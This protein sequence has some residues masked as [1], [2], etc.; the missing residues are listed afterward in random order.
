MKAKVR[1]ASIDDCNKLGPKLREADKRELKAS[2]GYGPVTALTLSMN[3][4][5]NAYVLADKDD[6]AVLMF[7]VVSS[8]QDS[9][10]V[11]W[12]L[13]SNGIYKHTRKLTTE[14]KT[15]LEFIHK[16]YDL[17]FN[18]VHAENPKAIRWL[19]WMGFTM[20]R[21]IPDYGVGKEPFYEFVKVK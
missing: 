11:P 12:M 5:D 6:M 18:Y 17:L 16:D 3:A 8:P 14:C 7:G 2:C 4:S 13:G 1:L 21:L 15:W 19:Q 9:V 20:V 10:G